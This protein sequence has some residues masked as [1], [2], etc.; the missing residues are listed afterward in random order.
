[1]NIYPNPSKNLINIKYTLIN[2][3]EMK[4]SISD[5]LGNKISEVLSEYQ[6][7]GLHTLNYPTSNLSSGSYFLNLEVNGNITSKKS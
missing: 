5:I 7:A 3:A 6:D 1:L 4:I 2:N